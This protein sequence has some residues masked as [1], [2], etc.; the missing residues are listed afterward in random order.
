MYLCTYALNLWRISVASDDSND[1][2]I[3]APYSNKNM[4]LVFFPENIATPFLLKL[5]NMY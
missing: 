1:R 3:P 5:D 2:I 4:K